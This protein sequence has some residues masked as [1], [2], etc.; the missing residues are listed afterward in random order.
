MF[1]GQI[2]NVS[3]LVLGVIPA[4][5]SST[6]ISALL[7]CLYYIFYSEFPID[8]HLQY[9]LSGEYLLSLYSPVLLH[10]PL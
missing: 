4:E 8:L 2:C 5:A 1:K 10:A 6:F 7:F 9:Y 3:S